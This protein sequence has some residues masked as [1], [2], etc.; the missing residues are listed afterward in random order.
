VRLI[1]TGDDTLRHIEEFPDAVKL[2]EA[3]HMGLDGS[4]SNACVAP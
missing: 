4:V 2:L 1:E 3:E